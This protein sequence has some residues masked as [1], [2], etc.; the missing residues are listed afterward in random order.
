MRSM[1]V[2]SS[3]SRSLHSKDLLVCVM[4]D[5]STLGV[6]I[7]NSLAKPAMGES[8]VNPRMP[9]FGDGPLWGTPAMTQHVSKVHSSHSSDRGPV[10]VSVNR[11]SRKI[12]TISS[13]TIQATNILL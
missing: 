4:V 7:N 10:Y 6:D 13:L 1:T 12:T 8:G 3:P 5:S 9:H 11:W 2:R